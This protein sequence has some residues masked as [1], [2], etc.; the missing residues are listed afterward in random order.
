MNLL[1]ITQ[2]I[3]T[4]IR[5]AIGLIDKVDVADVNQAIVNELYSSIVVDQNIINPKVEQIISQS[6]AFLKGLDFS[7]NF[8]KIGN[9]V[10]YNG[11]VNVNLNPVTEGQNILS[12]KIINPIYYPKL[13]TVNQNGNCLAFNNNNF[14][15]IQAKNNGVENSLTIN[16]TGQIAPSYNIINGFYVTEN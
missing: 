16:S 14:K 1:Q 11:Y 2:L 15:F 13:N 8:K 3:N 10:F 7:I 12:L 9:I 4:K 5:N 6:E